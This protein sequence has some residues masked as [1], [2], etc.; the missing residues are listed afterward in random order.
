MRLIDITEISNDQYMDFLRWSSMKNPESTWYP[1][2]IDRLTK[3]AGRVQGGNVIKKLL[4]DPEGWEL[5][6]FYRNTLV[7]PVEDGM[8]Q[9]S[10]YASYSL[11]SRFKAEK[12]LPP[13]TVIIL[14]T[15]RVDEQGHRWVSR[16]DVPVSSLQLEP[17]PVPTQSDIQWS[18]EEMARREIEKETTRIKSRWAFP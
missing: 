18:R 12:N 13:D 7:C 9:V 1:I 2:F 6:A 15:A 10:W 5:L 14:T 4:V 11:E 8:T 3:E 17:A 16:E